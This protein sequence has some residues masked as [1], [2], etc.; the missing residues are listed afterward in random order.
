MKKYKKR[1]FRFAF[2][3]FAMLLIYFSHFGEKVFA[4]DL[5]SSKKVYDAVQSVGSNVIYQDGYIYYATGDTSSSYSNQYDTLA[6]RIRLKKY[7][8]TWTSYINSSL[9]S[10]NGLFK[11]MPYEYQNINGRQWEFSAYKASLADIAE[12]MNGMGTEIAD[13]DFTLEFEFDFLI[14]T[15]FNG[16][17]TWSGYVDDAGVIRGTLYTDGNSAWTAIRD[18][19]IGSSEATRINVYNHYDVPFTV[20][21]ESK[22]ATRAYPG[23]FDTWTGYE[24]YR[25]N[26]AAE[27]YIP[28]SSSKERWYKAN[29]PIQIDNVVQSY[30]SSIYRAYFLLYDN[31]TGVLGSRRYVEY[32]G[33]NSYVTGSENSSDSAYTIIASRMHSDNNGSNS[34]RRF[35]LVFS[36]NGNK[37]IAYYGNGANSSYLLATPESTKGINSDRLI[38]IDATNPTLTFSPSS[39]SWG[40]GTVSVT[41]KPSDT[42]SGVKKWW[43]RL[44][45]DNGTTWGSWSSAIVGATSKTISLT[46]EGKWKIQTE[47]WDNVENGVDSYITSGTYQIDKTDPSGSFSPSSKTWG[48]TNVSVTFTPSDKGGSGV[49]RWRSRTSSDN[50][51]TWSSWSGYTS[52]TT[53]GTITISSQGQSKIEAEVYDNAGNSNTIKSGTYQIDKTAPTVKFNP[54]SK[55]WGNANIGVV[56]SFADTGGSGINQWRYRT[57]SNNGSTWSSWSSYSTSTSNYTVNLTTQG[58]HKIEVNITDK[59]G[60]STTTSSGV[61]QIDKTSPT[62]T[63]NPNSKTWGNASVSVAITPSDTGG[64]GVNSWKYRTSSDNGGTY[65]AWSTTYTDTTARTVSLSNTGVYKIQTYI[66]DKAGNT[67]TVTSGTYQID[68]AAPSIA[69][70]PNSVSWVNKTISVDIVLGDTGGS[71]LNR[72]RYRITNDNGATFNAWSSYYTT[73][74]STVTLSSENQYIIQ[75]YVED[76]AGNSTTKNSGVYQ[77]DKTK[78]SGTFSVTDSDWVKT[79]LTTTFTPSDTGGSGVAKYEY[80]LSSDNGTTYNSWV[81]KSGAGSTTFSLNQEGVWKVQVIVYDNAG[82][83]NTLTS[84]AFKIDKSLPTVEI[85]PTNRDWDNTSVAVTIKATDVSSSNYLSGLSSLQ[86]RVRSKNT[87]GDSWSTWVDHTIVDDTSIKG[88]TTY[89]KVITL[90]TNNATSKIWQVAARATDNAGNTSAYTFSE[91]TVGYRIDKV[92]PTGVFIPNSRGWDITSTTTTFTPSDSDSGVYRWRYRTSG[93]EGVTWGTWSS[94]II[95]ATSRNIQFITKG[96]WRIQAE[97]IDNANNIENLISGIYYITT[98]PIAQFTVNSPVLVGDNL[99]YTDNSYT[100]ED[101]ATIAARNWRW[102][103]NNSTWTTGKPTSFNLSEYSTTLESG[104]YY[105]QEQVTDSNGIVSDWSSSVVVRVYRKNTKPSASFSVT[106]N[107]QFITGTLNYTK[108]TNSSDAWDTI[109]SEEWSYSSNGGSTWSNSAS[110]PPTSF[111]SVG[112]Y[113]IRY[114][115]LDRGNSLSGGLWSDY[116]YQDV[117]I[118]K[119]VAEFSVGPNPNYTYLPLNYTDNSRTTIAGNNI[120]KREWSYSVD[121]GLTWSYPTNTP[122]TIFTERGDYKIRLRVSSTLSAIYPEVWSDYCVRNIRVLNNLYLTP[123]LDINPAKQGQKVTLTVLTR[124]YATNEIVRYPSEFK[125]GLVDRAVNVEFIHNEYYTFIVP[126]DTPVTIDANG[127][128]VRSPYTIV[129]DAVNNDGLAKTETVS[130]DVK[131]NVLDNIFTEIK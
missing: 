131:G 59:A 128:R 112:V 38:R 129:V 97:V 76:N 11:G 88:K 28:S 25:Y 35:Q 34:L 21:R 45:S 65:S 36:V 57:T 42:R 70:T 116:V 114:R 12:S 3:F 82:N 118:I 7:N 105:I 17:A 37:D 71:G 104:L 50:G 113:K 115:V 81:T 85:T 13:P 108:S 101:G 119:P 74:S 16:G 15:T 14:G 39:S 32:R 52:G 120:N 84:G 19:G 29:T 48:N 64:S 130:L 107:P 93:D 89:S 8:G 24:G 106:P 20:S 58:Q 94:Y 79:D 83:T 100:T 98:K 99:V 77:I 80:R 109:V 40:N 23:M 95:G 87:S 31:S 96:H 124:G 46:G 111:N 123:S 91:D 78:P 54:N 103:T 47:V 2:L 9:K 117:S 110:S 122:T 62:I 30:N 56:L 69:F 43:Y 33:L 1:F 90:D 102:S 121:N 41:M 61:Y 127:N 18:G 26:N 44:S 4:W 51:S 75:V 55:T 53:S 66:E 68:K 10:S 92:K 6:T 5:S 86:I 60:N 125:L 27:P 22:I 67:T 49:Y 72:W 126:L 63:Y 73:S